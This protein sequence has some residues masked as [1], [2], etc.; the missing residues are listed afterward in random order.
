MPIDMATLYAQY[1]A[2]AR[3]ESHNDHRLPARTPVVRRLPRGG[4]GAEIG[5]F[6]GVFSEFLIEQ[7]APREFYLVDAWDVGGA[8]AWEPPPDAPWSA[9][10]DHGNLTYEAARC[11]A[12]ARAGGHPVITARSVDWLASRPDHSLDWVYL[13]TTHRYGDTMK[14]LA[15]LSRVVRPDGIIAG[16]DAW[17]DDPNPDMGVLRAIRDFTRTHPWEI[18][19]LDDGQFTLRTDR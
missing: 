1:P 17:E 10:V 5:V 9:Y 11:A 18:F 13:D 12:R 6:T 4:V 7:T 3:V 8:S 19:Y 16:D 14:E 2:L 15:A